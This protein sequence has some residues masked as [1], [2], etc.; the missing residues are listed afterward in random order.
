[1]EWT[2]PNS[3]HKAGKQINLS[4]YEKCCRDESAL[5]LILMER[6][7]VSVRAKPLS[8]DDAKTSPWRIS[9]NS[10]SIPNLSKFEFGTLFLFTLTFHFHFLANLVLDLNLTLRRS[11]IQQQLRHCSSLRSSHQRHCRVHSSR[12]QRLACVASCKVSNCGCRPR[13]TKRFLESPWPL[14]WPNL[15]AKL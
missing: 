11:N 6:I 14:L 13:T 5:I 10:I 9:G 15:F 3:S 4:R 12:I 7:H 1:M 2:C 8:P